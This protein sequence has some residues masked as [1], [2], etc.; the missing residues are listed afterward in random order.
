[1]DYKEMNKGNYGYNC[2][3]QPKGKDKETKKEKECNGAILD[4][5]TL[6][7]CQSTCPQYFPHYKVPVVL[8][9]FT[10]QIDTESKIRLCEPAIEIKRIKKN[11][12]LTQCRLLGK[13]GKVFISGYVRKNI[14]Y[15][16]MDCC[17]CSAICGDIKHTTVHVPFQCVTELKNLRDPKLQFNPTTEEMAFYDPKNVGR[18]MKETDMYSEEYFNESVYCELVHASIY[19]ADI[20]HECD[21]V[22]CLPNEIVFQNFIE[23]EVILLKIKLLQNQQICEEKPPKYPKCDEKGK[24]YY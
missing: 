12:F 6:G 22:H 9:E 13:T 5:Y 23:K 4:S 10:V 2:D 18:N 20:V 21:K 3:C 16:T 7:E 17:N 11:V 14:E 24:E 19:E 8:S 15:A 1:M